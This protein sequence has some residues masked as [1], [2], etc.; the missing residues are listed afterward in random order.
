MVRLLPFQFTII[1]RTDQTGRANAVVPAADGT[2]GLAGGAALAGVVLPRLGLE[3]AGWIC[4]TASV[5]SVTL[6]M[7]ATTL[8]KM[9]AGRKQQSGAADAAAVEG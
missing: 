3:S 7:R 1:S 4:A 5:I 6:Y 8:S 9:S 2:L